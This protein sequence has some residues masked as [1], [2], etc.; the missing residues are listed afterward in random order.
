MTNLERMKH[1]A[2]NKP[3]ATPKVKPA[4]AEQR[5]AEVG[6]KVD[7][8]KDKGKHKVEA[9]PPPPPQELKKKHK[10]RPLPLTPEEREQLFKRKHRLPHGA[11]FQVNY[12]AEA[13]RWTGKLFIPGTAVA[14][15]HSGPGLYRMLSEL[16]DLYLATLKPAEE[17]KKEGEVPD[18][19]NV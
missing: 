16:D 7:G 8:K 10:H 3:A 1:A 11:C 14:F 4:S 18:G 13:V 5:T 19:G 2:A 15:D 12:D 6:K 9:K 17:P